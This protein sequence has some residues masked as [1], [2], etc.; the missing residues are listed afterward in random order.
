MRFINLL[1]EL[2][3]GNIS[4]ENINLL[5]RECKPVFNIYDKSNLTQK[6]IQPTLLFTT[7]KD[8]NQ[9]NLIN[10]RKIQNNNEG[11]IA[12]TVIYQSTDYYK[13]SYFLNKYKNAWP[14]QQKLELCVGKIK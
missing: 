13:S 2:R 6:K 3:I 14:V 12:Q 4:N 9:T 11:K 8:V 7:N 1:N 5:K 10:L